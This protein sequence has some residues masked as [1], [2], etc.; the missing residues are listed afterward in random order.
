MQRS[1]QQTRSA[2]DSAGTR[3]AGRS[4]ASRGATATALLLT[5]LALPVGAADGDAC[6][7][8]RALAR[9][10]AP[11]VESGATQIRVE[12]Q[13]D[14]RIKTVHAVRSVAAPLPALRQI[15][16]EHERLSEHSSSLRT[17]RVV[18]RQG[19]V[20]LV[21]QD[22][23]LP[24]PLRDRHYLLEVVDEQR[25]PRCFESRWVSVEGSGNIAY[26]KGRWEILARGD[27]TLLAYVAE[28]DPGGWVPAFAA[29]WAA[30]RAVPELV[31]NVAAAA[32]ALTEP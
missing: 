18:E 21:R 4:S 19:E 26:T 32:E 28:A 16:T 17:A 5:I 30:R 6:S 24:F 13:S 20:L 7:T 22:L 11:I 23:D 3:A 25:D 8:L 9:E 31:E 1:G 29:N 2:R 15:V 14:R 27:E 12:A 10:T